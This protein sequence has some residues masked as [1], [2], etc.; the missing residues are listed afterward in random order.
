MLENF[1]SIQL[2]VEYRYI[3]KSTLKV[4]AWSYDLPGAFKVPS[5]RWRL[6]TSLF[7]RHFL[8]GLGH[9]VYSFGLPFTLG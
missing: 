5:Q 4:P 7:S 3:P 6:E 9:L 1:A 2:Q 8:W